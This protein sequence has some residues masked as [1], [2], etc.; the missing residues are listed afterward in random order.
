MARL[1]PEL[2]ARG[3]EGRGNPSFPRSDRKAA[4]DGGRAE[5][6]VILAKVG[7][8]CA[9]PEGTIRAL[10]LRFPIRAAMF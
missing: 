10:H 4:G 1:V 5:A 6:G 3:K 7:M 2:A 9:R 8:I